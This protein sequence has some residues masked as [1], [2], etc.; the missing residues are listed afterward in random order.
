[1]KT[2]TH[3]KGHKWTNDELKTIMSMWAENA[4]LLD[5]A[6][7]V[8]STTVSV[9]KQV[10]RMRQNGIPLNKRRVG[11][12]KGV[13][14]GAWTQGE[15]EYLLRRRNEKS[16]SEE[17]GAQLNRSSNAVDAMIQKL[18]KEGVDIAMRGNGVRRL[19]S[20]ESLKAVALTEAL[21]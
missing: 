6:N 18:R 14:Y 19:W 20:A 12:Q 11:H 8:K 1:M 17:I 4:S 3:Y 9:L 15:V 2:T 21:Q 10:Q 5:I 13:K 7:A 16:T